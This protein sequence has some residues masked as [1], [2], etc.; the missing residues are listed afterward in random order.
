[1]PC[2]AS[3]R[4]ASSRLALWLLVAVIIPFLLFSE[5]VDIDG[6]GWTLVRHVPEGNKWHRAT[7]QLRGSDM[8]GTPCGETCNQEWSIKF[9]SINYNQFL[10]ATGDGHKW[11]IAAKNVVT[12]S[13]YE[14]KPRLICKSSRKASNYKAKW[15]RRKEN[16]EDPW[17]SLTDHD[18]AIGEGNI[19]YAE[20]NLTREHMTTILQEHKG[21]NVFIR[22]YGIVTLTFLFY[23]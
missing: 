13:F 20:N 22:I 8:Y 2:V 3:R 6:G 11:L 17:I 4:V 7:D 15:Y 23:C 9:A 19:I 12:G 18:T 21:A 5:T 16:R 14:N 10:F 1:M